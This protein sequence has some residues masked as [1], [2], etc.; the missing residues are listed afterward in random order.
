VVIIAGIF[1]VGTLRKRKQSGKK[2][3][4]INWK[5]T[6]NKFRHIFKK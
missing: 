2:T 1:G 5:T 3:P 6:W 4:L